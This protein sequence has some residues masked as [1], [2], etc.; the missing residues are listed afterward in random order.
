[1]TCQACSGIGWAPVSPRPAAVCGP[2]TPKRPHVAPCQAHRAVVAPAGKCYL[3]GAGPGPADLLTVRATQILRLADV[4]VFDDLGAQAAV[5]TYAPAA[6]QRVFVG[7]RGGRPSIKQPEIDSIIVQHA[8][9]GSTVVRLK[10]GCPSVFSRLHSEVAA[11]KASGIP[12][13]ICPGVSSALAAPLTAG[14][15][16]THPDLSRAFAVTSAHDPAAM[17]WPALAAMD[18]LVLLMGGKSLA[19]VVHE[20]QQ[21]GRAAETAVAVV[22]EAAGSEQQ[23]RRWQMRLS[24]VT[25]RTVRHHLSMASRATRPTTAAAQATACTAASPAQSLLRLRHQPCQTAPGTAAQSAFSRIRSRLLVQR[26]PRAVSTASRSQMDGASSAA[27]ADSAAVVSTSAAGAEAGGSAQAEGLEADEAQKEYVIVNFY[28]LVD[29]ERPHEVINRHK[30]WMEGKEVRGRVYISEQ[31]I[32]AQYGGVREDAE[33][34]A[35]WLAETQ[36]LFKGLSYSVWPAEGHQYP[37]LRLKYRPNLISLA[38][39]MA[40]LPV[41]DPGARA[42]PTQPAE[43]KRMLK[44]GRSSDKPPLMLDVRNSYEWDAG[45]FEGAA[46]PLEAH[47]HETPT[48]ALPNEVPQYLEDADPE[49]PVMIYCTGGIR[50]DVYGT[51]LRKKGFNKLYTLEGG[52]QNYMREE[53]LDHWNGSLFVFDGRMAI[54]QN[55]DQQEELEAAAPCQVCGATAVLP[56]MNCANIDCNKLFIACEACKGN[57]RGCCCEACTDAPRLLRPAKT[58]GQY[59]NWSQYT[60]E[61]GEGSR[62]AITSGRG[63]GR[64]SRRRKRLDAL[65]ARELE[66]RNVKLERRRQARELMA[67]LQQQMAQAGVTDAD[68]SGG[69]SSSSAGAES[70]SEQAARADRLA[71]LR[72]LRER[73]ASSSHA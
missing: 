56:H 54:R 25:A 24:L 18:T 26:A 5:E 66:K 60:A 3:V 59:G 63:E 47:F 41:T 67:T 7:K 19:A 29:I 69:S 23:R 45:H 14:F 61:E 53:G 16:L 55:K 9:A 17:D 35:R 30:D 73:L 40:S 37:K 22:R 28:H 46:R 43:W 65:R 52:I 48:E 64:I 32:N 70:G 49:R 1:M 12:Y 20:L 34:Y 68:D 72:E 11:L 33:G 4:V 36:P 27:A 39:G 44:E 15:P 21:Q 62:K 38:G 58:A 8:S 13:E 42:I 6:A 2:A 57:Y 10:G 50:C 51:Y 71:R 31:G